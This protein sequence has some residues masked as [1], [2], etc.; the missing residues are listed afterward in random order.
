MKS[1]SARVTM[2]FA[3]LV[4]CTTALVLFSGGWL[5]NL[6]MNE[7][8][9]LLNETEVA[10][11]KAMIDPVVADGNEVLERVRSHA[12][13]EAPLYF[14]QL[15]GPGGSI[16]FRSRNLGTATLPDIPF[17]PTDSVIDQPP[18]GRMLVSE[19]AAGEGHV[20]IASSLES[21]DRHMHEYVRIS[22]ILLIGVAVVSIGGGVIFSRYA[23]RPV[24][25]I[26]RT[27]TRINADN[28]GERIPLG[29]G[30]DEIAALGT[31]LNQ[32]FSRLEASFAQVRRFTADAS[33]ELKT[34]LAVMRL[35][36]EKLR[37]RLSEDAM[38][39]AMVDDQLEEMTRLQRIIDRLLFLARADSG[40]MKPVLRA[41]NLQPFITAFAEDAT[42]L[43]ED[44]G[45][46]FLL[47][48]NDAGRCA[49]EE[50][51]LQ[52][53]LF[54]VIGNALN[55]MEPGG[56]VTLASACTPAHWRVTVTD[57][58]PGLPED[59]LERVFERFVRY[60][61][62]DAAKRSEGLG[63]AICRSIAHL[64]GGVIQARNRFDRPG[65][66]VVVELPVTG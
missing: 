56:R 10:E 4:T 15:F 27:A 35:N 17:R 55:A 5:L 32:M 47:V 64:H 48:Q 8:Q 37:T 42:A 29:A 20:L 3:V 39:V 23:L 24:G 33:H 38:A 63:L 11:I 40:A 28:L 9:R 31:L 44:R 6:Q 36:A 65:L 7:G 58:G 49:I 45:M 34:P 62:P 53:L 66:Q 1:L 52:Q 60:G 61:Q 13:T 46:Q 19:L 26:A 18:M 16:R 25:D 2:V 50:T 43:T 21:L 12:E 51:L 14:F 54:N 41:Q 22:A 30:Q 59:Q 57:E